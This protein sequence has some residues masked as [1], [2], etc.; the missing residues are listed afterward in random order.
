MQLLVTPDQ[1]SRLFEPGRPPLFLPDIG[2]YFNQDMEMAHALVDKLADSGSRFIKGEILHDARICLPEAGKECYWSHQDNRFIEEDYRA[3]IERK[4]VSLDAY[5]DLFD[6]CRQRELRLVLSVYDFEGADFAK[7]IGAMA[8]KIAS[9]NITHQP[10]IEHIAS[11]GLPILLDTGHA[12]LEEIARA[13]NWIQDAGGT[14]IILQHSPPGPPSPPEQHNLR[15]MFTLSSSFACPVGLS[16][17]FSGP[18]MLYAAT[19]MGVPL[20]EKGVCPDHMGNEQDG[21]HA[22]PI[23]RVAETL[24]HIE[25]I[26]KALGDGQ[27]K[28][29]RSREK[30]RSRTGLISKRTLQAGDEITLDTVRFAFPAK[31][32]GTEYWSEVKNWRVR[33][34]IPEGQVI[35]WCDVEPVAP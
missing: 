10:L 18:D 32:I 33:T 17:H 24:S 28:L 14:G 7:E 29:P 30:Y 8:L 2:T 6:H 19:A 3:L 25:T 22:L 20:L 21:S 15:F 12:T 16:D 34:T 9:S 1:E 35:D 31:G 27:R 4:V 26:H 13:V 23:S 5:A 11:L